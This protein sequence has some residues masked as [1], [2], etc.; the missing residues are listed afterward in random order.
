MYSFFN[1]ILAPI[2]V[3]IPTAAITVVVYKIQER[4]KELMR[5]KQEQFDGF[6][7][8]AYHIIRR[9]STDEIGFG[10]FEIAEKE[11]GDLASAIHH[12][13]ELVER[14]RV[15]INDTFYLYI[16][17]IDLTRPAE[18]R[19]RFEVVGKEILRQYDMWKYTVE[20]KDDIPLKEKIKVVRKSNIRGSRR[21]KY[22]VWGGLI[23]QTAKMFS[24]VF[25]L[26]LVVILLLAGAFHYW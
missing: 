1:S 9:V 8:P 6:I 18:A 17:S 25:V 7:E 20:I 21:Y 22:F 12:L 26:V 16:D 3:A 15:M 23:A 10:I 24:G 14:E 19:H 5:V 11:P 2:I 13:K 4:W